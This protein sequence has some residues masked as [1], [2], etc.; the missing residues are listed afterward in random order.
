LDG[1]KTWDDYPEPQFPDYKKY[2]NLSGE[3]SWF[4]VFFSFGGGYV[5]TFSMLIWLSGRNVHWNIFYS[6]MPGLIHPTSWIT[7]RLSRTRSSVQISTLS[8]KN[9]ASERSISYNSGR[10]RVLCSRG[11]RRKTPFAQLTS[12][13]NDIE[14][15]SRLFPKECVRPASRR[16]CSD[17]AWY[18]IRIRI[19]AE[20][21]PRRSSHHRPTFITTL[22]NPSLKKVPNMVCKSCF[23]NTCPNCDRQPSTNCNTA[24]TKEVC[25]DCDCG[26]DKKWIA[27]SRLELTMDAFNF[28]DTGSWKGWGRDSD[29]QMYYLERRY[30]MILWMRDSF[31]SVVWSYRLAYKIYWQISTFAS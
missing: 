24:G 19:N 8:K 22:T 12:W 2:S 30:W 4:C 10:R 26:K 17:W 20:S 16:A 23:A 28:R 18:Q 13:T 11:L 6:Y 9:Y 14:A 25:A 27:V 21:H 5:L 7:T 1:D 31:W 3:F 29:N 15:L